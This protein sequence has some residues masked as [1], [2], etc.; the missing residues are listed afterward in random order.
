MNLLKIFKNIN[1]DYSYLGLFI[2]NKAFI[3]DGKLQGDAK[4]LGEKILKK[5]GEK[6]FKKIRKQI[7][8]KFYSQK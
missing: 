3:A 6:N 4:I 2:S 8:L 7:K 5:L 1:S